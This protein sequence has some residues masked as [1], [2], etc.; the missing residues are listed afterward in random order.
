MKYVKTVNTFLNYGANLRQTAGGS[1][2][3]QDLKLEESRIDIRTFSGGKWIELQLLFDGPDKL[4]FKSV[5]SDPALPTMTGRFL[6]SRYEENISSTL[7]EDKKVV[8]TGTVTRLGE[9]TAVSVKT[10]TSLDT[11]KVVAVLQELIELITEAE[12][13]A[14]TQVSA[15]P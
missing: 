7:I 12:F 6:D 10:I 8:V 14:G 11:G 1:Y 5:S 15:Q 13:L 4:D 9:S 3:T 2:F